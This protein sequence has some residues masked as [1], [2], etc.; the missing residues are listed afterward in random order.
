MSMYKMI[1]R[2]ESWIKKSIKVW[3]GLSKNGQYK[4][5]KN[6]NMKLKK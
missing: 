5:C 2:I 4:L 1:I 6:M 3:C